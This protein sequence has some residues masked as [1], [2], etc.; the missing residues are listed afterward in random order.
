MDGKNGLSHF[1]TD[2]ITIFPTRTR[3]DSKHGLSECNP[4]KTQNGQEEILFELEMSYKK[5]LLP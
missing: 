3:R 4:T 2:S 1:Q 5:F